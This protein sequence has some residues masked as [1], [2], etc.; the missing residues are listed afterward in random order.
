MTRWTFKSTDEGGNWYYI[1]DGDGNYL[2][3]GDGNNSYVRVSSDPQAIYVRPNGNTVRL[4]RSAEDKSTAVNNYSGKADQ[5]FGPYNDEG[6]NEWFTLLNL[7][8]KDE[9]KVGVYVYVAAND[10][11]NNEEFK[12]S[13]GINYVDKYGY[14]PASVVYLPESY[15]E[16]RT[17]TSKLINT[18]EDWDILID[19]ISEMDTSYLTGD[20]VANKDN[21]ISEYVDQIVRDLNYGPSSQHS[22]LATNTGNQGFEN[23]GYGYHLDL[24]FEANQITF[25][26]GN[27]G[28]TDN[29]Y[30]KAKDGTLVDTRTYIPGAE[31]Q[32]PRNLEIPSGYRFMGYYEDADFTIPWNGI[33]ELLYEDKVVYI[34]I[35][36]EDNVVLNYRTVPG[37]DAGSPTVYEEGLNPLT[38][39]AKGSK[40]SAKPGYR[41]VGWYADEECTDL[42]SANETFVPTKSGQRWT[43]GTTYYAKFEEKT[44]TLTF[45]AEEHIDHL[46]L[47]GEP[48][49]VV[50][51]DLSDDGK[52][53]TVVLK[54][55]SGSPVTVKGIPED[56]YAVKEWMINDLSDS[57]TKADSL[58]TAKADD[59]SANG[60]WTERTYHVWAEVLKTITVSKEVKIIG[61]LQHSPEDADGKVYFALKDMSQNPAP[62]VCNADGSVYTVSISIVDGEPKGTAQFVDL[63]AGTY[64]VWEVAD[65]NAG[66]F[67]PGSTLCEGVVVSRIQTWISETDTGNDVILSE[68]DPHGDI[69]VINTLNHAG[70]ATTFWANKKWYPEKN[71]YAD[72]NAGA[73]VNVPDGAWAEFTLYRVYSDGSEEKVETIRLDG[74]KNEIGEEEAWAAA[75]RDLETKDEYGKPVSYYVKETAVSDLSAYDYYVTFTDTTKTNGGSIAN[76]VAY[77]N[78]Q[79]S[80]EID[81]PADVSD[82]DKKAFINALKITAV[83]PMEADESRRISVTLDNSDQRT[84]NDFTVS[85]TTKSVAYGTTTQNVL[86]MTLTATM[87]D[88]PAGTYTVTET[89]YND[90]ELAYHW[91]ATNSWIKADKMPADQ[92]DLANAEQT[93]KNSTNALVGWNVTDDNFTTKVD[94]L[95]SYV[96]KDIKATKVWN[97]L[98]QESPN[99]P[100]VPVTLYRTDATGKKTAVSTQTIGANQTGDKLTL[101]WPNQPQNYTYSVEEGPVR[102]Y[103]LESITGNEDEGFIITNKKAAVIK[104][105]KTDQEGN[106]LADAVFSSN[107]FEGNVKTVITGEEDDREAIIL[108]TTNVPI[109]E[110]T[111]T[112]AAP[113]SGYNSLEGPVKITVAEGSAAGDIVVTATIN[114]QTSAF[115]EVERVNVSGSAPE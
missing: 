62:W 31:V 112:E 32:E 58:T 104:I 24:R 80:K 71:A 74:T 81:L 113:P 114:G 84:D 8:S 48:E 67:G 70:E 22:T 54:A 23:L 20:A 97:D 21:K 75:F 1:Q 10:W 96:V 105:V 41:F 43:D 64:E 2:N 36:E 29:K 60:L 47:S 69:K 83:G 109:G 56:G 98:E 92:S 77:G 59:T 15:F 78:I 88:L 13:I 49:N 51:S 63:P 39:E 28:L 3:I 111:L 35:T 5:G 17:D 53:L 73:N 94:I 50:S 89:G 102:G 72:A 40:A 95:N 26:T 55:S 34:K 106:P 25:Y 42:L 52:T 9:G 6:T 68:E 61:T 110:Y 90:P 4:Q 99:H 66:S 115:A 27:N 30:G 16:G 82:E 103:T 85:Q 79:I 46:E 87:L 33:G 57:L 101:T 65:E 86:A 18:N 37:N 44:V 107:L 100:S 93:G 38:G 11:K 76:V 14:F 12:K 45:K 91:N 7:D 19:A 108:D